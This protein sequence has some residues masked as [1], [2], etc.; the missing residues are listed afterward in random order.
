M[1]DSQHHLDDKEHLTVFAAPDDLTSLDMT[2]DHVLVP[3]VNRLSRKVDNNANYGVM[4]DR[5][6]LAGYR[7]NGTYMDKTDEIKPSYLV[8]R[9]LDMWVESHRQAVADGNA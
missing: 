7:D 3:N 5:E 9:A 8:R 4:P 6:K 2:D 1:D